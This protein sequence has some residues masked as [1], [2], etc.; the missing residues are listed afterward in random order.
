[1]TQYRTLTA[2]SGQLALDT[3]IVRN[4]QVCR[5]GSL[6]VTASSVNK[7]QK[8]QL[9][10]PQAAALLLLLTSPFKAVA[11]CCLV[12]CLPLLACQYTPGAIQI[13][14]TDSTLT[15]PLS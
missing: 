1:M 3:A 13:A 5:A 9:M 14:H 8:K 2:K 11:N 7:T 10:M 12:S 15:Q 6:V 4:C